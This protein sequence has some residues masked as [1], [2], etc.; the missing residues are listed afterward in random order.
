[1]L[2]HTSVRNYAEVVDA[3]VHINGQ[4][5]TAEHCMPPARH[6]TPHASFLLQSVTAIILCC[7]LLG[8]HHNKPSHKPRH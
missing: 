4:S 7:M 3:K 6:Q 8:C 1:M 5:S 2:L